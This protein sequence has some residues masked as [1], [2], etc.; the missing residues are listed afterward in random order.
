MIQCLDGGFLASVAII[1]F[2]FVCCGAISL[3]DLVPSKTVFTLAASCLDPN[4]LLSVW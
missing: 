1:K 3:K 4:Y 2:W